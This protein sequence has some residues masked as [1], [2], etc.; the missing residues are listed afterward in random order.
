ML[1]DFEGCCKRAE[2]ALKRS[3][4]YLQLVIDT[5]PGLVWSALPDGFM[6]YL[7]QRWIDYIGLTLEEAS[8]WGWQT[9]IHPDDLP[10]LLDFRNLRALRKE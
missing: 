4:D 10:A 3:E 5:I 1:N 2:K 8:G 9:A 6:E 7:N